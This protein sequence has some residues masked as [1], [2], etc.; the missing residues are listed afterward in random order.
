MTAEELNGLEVG[1]KIKD[2]KGNI[3]SV[4][5]INNVRCIRFE[6][7]GRLKYTFFGKI[8]AGEIEMVG[9]E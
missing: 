6:I 5:R 2:N 4:V 8:I 7:K 9:D 1:Q 3:G